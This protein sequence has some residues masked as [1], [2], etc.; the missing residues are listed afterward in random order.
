M[1]STDAPGQSSAAHDRG[2]RL[3]Y[4]ERTRAYARKRSAKGPNRR[5]ILRCLK[6]YIARETYDTLRAD[7]RALN[8]T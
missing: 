8:S 6:G 5:E 1:R 7:L 2:L 4:C 3:R